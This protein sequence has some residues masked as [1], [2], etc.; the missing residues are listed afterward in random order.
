VDAD[1]L[2]PAAIR[3]GDAET[4][5]KARVAVYFSM[6]LLVQCAIYIPT[7]AMQGYPSL[8]LYIATGGVLL[9]L[10]PLTL[11]IP[12][13]LPWVGAQISLLTFGVLTATGVYTGGLESTSLWWMCM[14]PVVAMLVSGKKLALTMA[15][16]HVAIVAAF[17]RIDA[18]GYAWPSG[19]DP[20]T[21]PEIIFGDVVLLMATLVALAWAFEKA[22]DLALDVLAS[23]NRELRLILDSVGQGF[24]CCDPSGTVVG[25]QSAIVERWFGPGV[26]G[27]KIWTYLARSNASFSEWLRLGWGAISDDFLPLELCLDQLPKRFTRGDRSFQLEYQPVRVDGALSQIV[28]VISDVSA[29][30]EMEREEETQRELSDA[31]DRALRD[32]AGFLQFIEEGERLMSRLDASDPALKRDLHTIKGNCGFFGARSIAAASHALEDKLSEGPIATA[33]IE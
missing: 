6:A 30:V 4:L 23:H 32:R 18:S 10:V 25:R 19:P 28:I 24:L 5:R 12:R 20:H 33:E 8:S 9:C 7:Y 14:V 2:I 22:K 31:L 13:P 15:G 17:D 21:H 26:Q 1:R 11:R 29:I 27:Q 3:A 16:L